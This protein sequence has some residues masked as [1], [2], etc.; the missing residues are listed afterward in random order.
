MKHPI[1]QAA[2]LVAL[3]ACNQTPA[4]DAEANAAAGNAAAAAPIVLPPAITA[5]KTFRCKD[6]SLLYV[7]F[8][9]GDTQATIRTEP[10]GTPVMMK[11]EKAGD[12]FTA[13]GGYSL[14]GTGDTVEAAVPGKPEQSCHV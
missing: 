4:T 6:N 10:T 14:K 9:Q 1:L 12:P 8:F 3:A 5:E 13:E 2:A 11:A 7:T